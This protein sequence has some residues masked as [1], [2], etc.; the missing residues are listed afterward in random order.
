MYETTIGIVG[1][2]L[3]LFGFIANELN[4]IKRRSY[5][6]N[7]VNFFGALFLGIYAFLLGNKIFVFL[8][9]VWVAISLYFIFKVYYM[10]QKPAGASKRR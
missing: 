6:Y 1:L 3:I 9:V 10:R 8:E 5:T 4:F 2:V 7:I